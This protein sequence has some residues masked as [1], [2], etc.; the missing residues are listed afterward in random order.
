MSQHTELA[1]A[2]D[3]LKDVSL[4]CVG[5]LMLDCF[6]YGHVD[7]ISPEA[8]IPVLRIEREVSMLG[9]AGN[10]ARNIVGLGARAEFASVVGSDPPGRVSLTQWA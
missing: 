10:V 6:V 3:R 7:R 8:P 5:D 2:V 1:A 9:G 4:L